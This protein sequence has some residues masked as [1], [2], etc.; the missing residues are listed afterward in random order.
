LDATDECPKARNS[1][2]ALNIFNRMS[3]DSKIIF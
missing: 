1:C 2:I 3:Q